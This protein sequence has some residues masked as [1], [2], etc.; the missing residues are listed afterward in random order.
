M[1]E[2]K[3][4][5]WGGSE[6]IYIT[7]LYWF[8][9]NFYHSHNDNHGDI[10]MQYTGLRD[11]NGKE[12]YEG[13]ILKTDSTVVGEVVYHS[14]RAAFIFRDGYNEA[15]YQRMPYGIKVIGNIYENP[16]LLETA[17]KQ[18]LTDKQ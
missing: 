6:M 13:D 12:I 10:V 3:F 9:E 16:E 8:E 15:L 4:R 2:I 17:K 5:A 14:E 11:E 18:N 7:D 1:R